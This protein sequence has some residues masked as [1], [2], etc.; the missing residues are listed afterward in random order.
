VERFN[1]KTTVFVLLMI[2][3]GNYGFSQSPAPKKLV[4][5]TSNFKLISEVEVKPQF[6][7][8]IEKF[9]KFVGNNFRRPENDL[10]GK[11]VVAFIIEKDGSLS[12]FEV[13]SNE[14]GITAE[15][16]FIRVLKKCPKWIPGYHNGV[17]VRVKTHVPLELQKG[18]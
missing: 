10:Y 16:E 13:E 1:P 15:Q 4:A 8:G 18:L 2:A 14:L 11:I 6:S 12:N 3:F 7:D 17:C 9:Y 5:E